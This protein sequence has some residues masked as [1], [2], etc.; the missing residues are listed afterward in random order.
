MMDN[1][2]RDMQVLRKADSLIARIWLNVLARRL[3]LMVFAALIAVFGLGM[4]NLAGFY[5]LQPLL[6]PIWAAVTVAAV[7]FAL[8][9]VVLVVAANAKP[10]PAIDLALEMRKTAVEALQ[11]DARELRTTV[12]S[13]GAQLRDIKSSVASF[14]HNPLDAAAQG[15]LIPAA[16]A[17]LKGLR[18]KKE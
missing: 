9:V 2:I 7:D 1:L 4:A 11:A 15:V 16:L 17:I 12:E 13:L 6:G 5:A 10:D 8:A 3:A 18:A 14:V